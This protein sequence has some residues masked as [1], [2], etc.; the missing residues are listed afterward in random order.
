MVDT[1][2]NP[3][4]YDMVDEVFVGGKYLSFK[5]GDKGRII[6]IRLASEP[7]YINQ[8][9]VLGSD[10]KQTPINCKGDTCPYCGKD[11][12]QKEKLPKTAKW[13]WIVIDREDESVKI[14]TGPTLIAKSVKDLSE[15]V[16]KKTGAV[17]WGNPSTFDIQIERTEIPGASYYKVDPIPEGKGEMTEEEKNKVKEAGYDLVTELEGSKKSEHVGAYKANELETAPGEAVQETNV[18][19]DVNPDDIPF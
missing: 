9:W 12:P 13:G 7:R 15:M 11:I 1:N 17:I 4:G 14:F 3:Y 16:N 5:K 10:G 8:H 2:K 6:Q 18:N 19:E